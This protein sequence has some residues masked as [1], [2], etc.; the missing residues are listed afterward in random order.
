MAVKPIPD[1][2]STVTPYLYIKGAANALE[3]YKKAFGATELFRMDWNGKLGH[4][5]MQIGSSRV[6]MADEFPEMGA[7][8]PHTLGGSAIGLCLYVEDCDALFHR[9]VSAGATVVRPLQDQFYGDRSGT[10]TDP[11]GHVWTIA[12]HKE[13]V[14]PDEMEK[15]AAEAMKSMA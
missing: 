10:V 13:D 6:M 7:K 5:E 4:A 11:F 2:Y 15:R 8:G 14:A 3:F 1:G 12:T 9:A